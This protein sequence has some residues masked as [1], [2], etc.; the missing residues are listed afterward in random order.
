MEE[1]SDD[2]S[3]RT[4]KCSLNTFCNDEDVKERINEFVL[5]ANKLMFEAYAFA[6]LHV[7]RL[8]RDNKD[9]PPLDQKFFQS[10]CVYVSETYE[11]KSQKPKDT[12]MLKTYKIYKSCRP[13]TYKPPFRDYCGEVINYIKKDMVVSTTNH[14][15]LNFYKRFTKYLRHRYDYDG[16]KIYNLVKNI[17]A[18]E[19]DGDDDEILFW[20]GR[21]GDKPPYAKYIK[22]DPTNILKIYDEISSY[23]V[24]HNADKGLTKYR[25]FSL[26]PHKNS[27]TMSYI[28]ID[29][30]V[31][32][33]IINS[34]KKKPVNNE[35]IST[36]NAMH[37]TLFKN[38]IKNNPN[39]YWNM[40]YK[41]KK[42]DEFANI[43]KTDGKSV[44]IMYNTQRPSKIKKPKKKSTD[45]NPSEYD[46]IRAFDPGYRYM[47]VGT[48]T[49]D[50]NS[51]ALIKC[52]SREYYEKCKMTEATKKVQVIYDGD[53]E[54]IDIFVN[55]PTNKTND[56]SCYMSY[57]R[58]A[59]SNLDY[60]LHFHYAK[61]FRQLRFTTHIFRQK[62]M[63]ELCKR[64]TNKKNPHD[65]NTKALIGIGNWSSQHDSII[66][67]HRRGPIVALKR[68][69]KRWCKLVE[70]DEFRTSVTCYKCHS[71]TEKMS[72]DNV[73]VNSVL[74]CSNNECGTILDRDV[75]GCKNILHIFDSMLRN[76]PRPEAFCRK[77]LSHQ[78][79]A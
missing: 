48:D 37:N 71:N 11:R 29:K 78:K 35:K 38:E 76:L 17:Y 3:F 39:E 28:T 26:L 79:M 70:V 13:S 19:Y 18:E 42:I 63:H 9:I 66:R 44:S 46:V 5:N 45:D 21:L 72:Y 51:D 68:E 34:F 65:K 40:F 32:R 54:I 22:Q 47:F 41:I 67:G 57:L 30:G 69:L 58:Y 49:C 25:T 8:L 12:D 15:V 20:R 74:R 2:D 73:Q 27:F 7:L 14:L 53:P 23:I 52:S 24:K 60:L 77:K 6:N 33:D 50:T 55:M 59:L 75:N 36:C 31:L 62:T 1:D 16:R 56:V 10:C 61:S 4:V 64:I 43:V